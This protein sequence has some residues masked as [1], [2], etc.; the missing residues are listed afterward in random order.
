MESISGENSI[1]IRAEDE[2]SSI[3]CLQ[4]GYPLHVHWDSKLCCTSCKF[5][6]NYLLCCTV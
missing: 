6:V 1:S 4:V 3:V 5:Y 2:L